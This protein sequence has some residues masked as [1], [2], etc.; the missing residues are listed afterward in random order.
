MLTLVKNEPKRMRSRIDLHDKSVLRSVATT[1]SENRKSFEPGAAALGPRACYSDAKTV[2]SAWVLGQPVDVAAQRL[3]N[4][5]CVDCRMPSME[6]QKADEYTRNR[7]M[8]V[9]QAGYDAL[10][11][12][13]YGEKAAR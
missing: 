9:A 7:V 3:L 1:I 2:I 8:L 4:W 5:W 12:I 6:L 10:R 13:E 11:E